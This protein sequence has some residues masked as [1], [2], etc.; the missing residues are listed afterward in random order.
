[1]GSMITAKCDCGYMTGNMLLGHGMGG[2]PNNF[3]YY[4]KKCKSLFI[5]DANS[6]EVIHCNDTDVIAYND[7][8]IV[9]SLENTCFEWDDLKL[10][11]EKN[12]LC[13]EC[14]NF[15]LKFSDAGCWD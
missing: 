11:G 5:A 15:S 7:E 10:S 8:R 2:G 13:P 4:C 3:P 14:S 12:S 6:E 1:M 9:K